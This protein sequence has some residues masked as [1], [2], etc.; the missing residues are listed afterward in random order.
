[1]AAT[2][3]WA[4]GVE[5]LGAAY[6]GWQR[7]LEQPSLQAAVESALSAIAASPINVTAAGRTDTGVHAALQI[8]HFE[9]TVERE[10]TSWV[11]GGNQHLPSDVAIRWA[12]PVDNDF[13]ARFSALSRRYVYLLAAQ[14][15]RPGLHATRVGWTHWPQELARIEAA[16]PSLL[17]AH[18]F[19]AFRASECQ[20]KSPV[21][22]IYAATAQI[23]NGVIR[24]DF[25]A[26]AFL[27]H[28]IRN[29]VGALVYIGNGRQPTDW[30]ATLLRG[31][32]RTL[33][34]PTFSP[35]GLYLAGIE[36]DRKYDLPEGFVDPRL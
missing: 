31:K 2:Q 25:H 35:S 24:F 9:T 15:Y 22:T 1:M 29:I 5:Y 17:G 14:P 10:A 27:H 28:M 16:L 33:A 34:A 8:I 30:M 36:Y 13:H 7:Q 4:L 21:K 19:S 18:D 12:Q 20:A 23:A 6:C 11:R 26:N 3:R 32:D